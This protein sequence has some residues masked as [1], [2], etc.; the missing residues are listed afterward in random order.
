MRIQQP[1]NCQ[2]SEVLNKG[3][4]FL[5]AVRYRYCDK[6][7]DLQG[8]VFKKNRI[9]PTVHLF[10]F[11]VPRGR[12]DQHF[13]LLLSCNMPPVN[14]T[15]LSPHVT[16]LLRLATATAAPQPS[17]C[18]SNQIPSQYLTD[19]QLLDFERIFSE[20]LPP[21][22]S[23]SADKSADWYRTAAA[24]LAPVFAQATAVTPAILAE[25]ENAGKCCKL[26]KSQNST[27]KVRIKKIL[28]SDLAVA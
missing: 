8:S 6:L 3:L 19:R 4:R 28:W 10:V 5:R 27:L 9:R 7:A 23:P 12:S 25:W 17:S 13:K 1:L 26:A 14:K 21:P 11:Q 15:F 22:A 24:A 20:L 2:I 18:C 16:E